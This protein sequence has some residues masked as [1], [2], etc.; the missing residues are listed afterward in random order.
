[1]AYLCLRSL[2]KDVS[3]FLLHKAT[4]HDLSLCSIKQERI[5]L[6]ALLVRM[7]LSLC[8]IKQEC[9]ISLCVL[10]VRTYLSVPLP[11]VV[12]LCVCPFQQWCI[13][14]C[15]PSSNGIDLFIPFKQGRVSCL[16]IQS[17]TVC[18]C[19]CCCRCFY[20]KS[21]FNTSRHSSTNTQNRISRQASLFSCHRLI[22]YLSV[23]CLENEGVCS[24]ISHIFC[25]ALL[26]QRS[27]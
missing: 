23:R 26:N 20:S 16:I 2:T 19:C 21:V 17:K 13:S 15:A 24:E 4:V 11:G 14:V 22:D 8:S 5:S 25:V 10:L 27:F 18:C 7:Y 12:H 6:C 1:M 9:V 3:L